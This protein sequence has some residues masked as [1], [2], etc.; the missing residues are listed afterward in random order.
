MW[1]GIVRAG[2]G[3]AEGA[4]RH[5]ERAVA[6]ANEGGRA[7]AR[8]E[9]F[10][11]LALVAAGLVA[12]R[13]EDGA[14]ATD[15]EAPGAALVAL[16]DRSA[17]QV[18]ELLPLLPGHAPWGAQA[19]AALAT[20]A[21]ERGDVE[22]AVAAGRAA[23]EA[24]RNGMHED[25]RLEIMLP[26]ARAV[27]AGAPSEVQA[28]VRDYLHTALSRIA[29]ATA[30]EAVRVRWLTSPVGR[31]LAEL[32]G[33]DVPTGRRPRSGCRVRRRAPSG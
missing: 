10:A 29:Q 18:K 9:S 5:L 23:F 24:L 12:S 20:V 33:S 7:S 13:T 4:I 17:A 2:A 30:D 28:F 21:L 11:R 31:Q 26:A 14:A 27:L 25:T 22:A 6:I 15:G 8:C 16:V 3:D 32:A 19:D 1:R